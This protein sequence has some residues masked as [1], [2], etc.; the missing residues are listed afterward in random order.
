MK[1]IAILSLFLSLGLIFVQPLQADT[2]NYAIQA[3]FAYEG[4]DPLGIGSGTGTLSLNLILA[5]SP[6]NSYSF[7]FLSEARYNF[8]GQSTVTLSGT[9]SDGTYP[10]V[11]GTA[12]LD[13][14]FSNSIGPSHR[15]YF[16]FRPEFIISGNLMSSHIEVGLPES[17]WGDGE[18]PLPTLL[19]Q[20]DVNFASGYIVTPGVPG[21][22]DYQVNYHFTNDTLP[23]ALTVSSQVVP[24]P[25]TIW[26]LGS[27]LLGLAGWRRFRKG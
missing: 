23:T 19:S 2:I 9:N 12:E 25:P 8:Y 21:G 5:S 24:V 16:D 6:S 7:S 4:P 10:V 26:L 18:A 27:S 17:F 14:F 20:S 15:D 11:S 1:R 13:N 3:N 22:L